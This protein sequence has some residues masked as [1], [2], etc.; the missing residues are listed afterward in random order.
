MLVRVGHRQALRGCRYA[1]AQ[2]AAQVAG[3]PHLRYV[4]G[5]AAI[6]LRT[7]QRIESP[8]DALAIVRAVERRFG[9]AADYQ[10]FRDAENSS[11][12][13]FIAHFAFWDP[14]AYARVPQK[15]TI[16]RVKLPPVND[17]LMAGGIGLADAAPYLEPQDW[18]DNDLA[19]E[20]DAHSVY[21]PP[22]GGSRIIEV[23]VDHATG[24]ALLKRDAKRG[25]GFNDGRAQFSIMTNF[26]RWGGFAPKEPLPADVPNITRSD[27]WFGNANIDHVRMRNQ[28]DVWRNL[29]HSEPRRTPMHTTTQQTREAAA[30]SERVRPAD[31]RPRTPSAAQPAQQPKEDAPIVQSTELSFESAPAASPSADAST[32]PAPSSISLES[33]AESQSSA[34]TSPASTSEP[35]A[36][37]AT[38]ATPQTQVA[39]PATAAQPKPAAKPAPERRNQARSA[40]VVTQKIK[41]DEPVVATSANQPKAKGKAGAAPQAQQPQ[42]RHRKEAAPAPA[43]TLEERPIEVEERATGM[44]ARLKGLMKGWL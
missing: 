16:L 25:T 28:L 20:V 37:P 13:Q 42:R 5:S 18:P 15:S 26:V 12:Y 30:T 7:T 23:S 4:L 36:Q 38:A 34:P 21:E 3:H 39:K 33:E 31:P 27:L 24:R 6:L 14:A 22:T 11:Q 43:P 32:S 9:R 41:P 17:N 19:A 8:I 40:R 2:G 35:P 10:F 29:T 44:S 1:S